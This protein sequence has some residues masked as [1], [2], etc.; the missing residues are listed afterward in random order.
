[1]GNAEYMGSPPETTNQ[2]K[3]RMP[4][5]PAPAAPMC[6]ACQVR[7]YPA[8][9]VMAADRKPFH[10]KCVKCRTCGK[11]L[12]PATLNEHQT[13]LYCNPCYENIFIA[14]DYVCGKYGGIVTPEDLLRAEEEERKMKERKERA[15]KERRC[16]GCDMRSYPIDSVQLG[17]IFFHKACLKCTECKRG[18]DADTPMMLGPKD[19]SA[20][21]FGNDDE[22]LEPYCKFCFAKKYNISAL[23]IQEMVCTLV[24]EQAAQENMASL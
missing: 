10:K 13:Q 11:G 17:D 4:W 21:V 24:E 6:P 2:E 15:K 1:M 7:V 9:A 19:N 16:P 23:N 14:H 18:A 8:E 22:D 12:T 5:T 3:P 20:S